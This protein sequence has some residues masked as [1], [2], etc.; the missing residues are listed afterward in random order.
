MV[1]WKPEADRLRAEG[2]NNTQIADRLIAQHG[3]KLSNNAMRKRI[4]R[5]FWRQDDPIKVEVKAAQPDKLIVVENQEPTITEVKWK[6]NQIV[7]F[8]LVGDTHL[9]SKY[10]QLTHLHNI[11]D[12]FAQEGIKHVYH[13]GDIDEGEQM[14]PGHQYECY[15][16]GADDHVA[17]IV[18][19]YPKREGITT[20]FITGNHDAS[21][22]KRCG[23]NFGPVLAEKRSDLQYLGADCAIVKLTPNCSIELRHPWN[24]SSYAI[25]YQPQKMM[26]AMSGGE[27]PNIL[28][29]GHY[30]K[31]E[32]IFYRNIHCFQTGTLC[33]QTPFMRGKGLAAHMGGWIVEIEVDEQGSIKRIMPQFIPFYVAI[34]DDYMSFSGGRR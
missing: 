33:A 25:S 13:T 2:L 32:Y 10:T 24:G 3:I 23:Y 8:G 31:A 4:A 26:D 12:R 7:R 22:I 15:T 18:A 5:H 34:K 1:N 19:N 27:K 30:H 29:I 14:R 28:A 17:E 16:Q 21:T 20:H 9:N 11:Y 6:G